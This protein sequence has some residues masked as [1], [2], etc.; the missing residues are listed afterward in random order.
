MAPRVCSM[1]PVA[2]RQ[3][4][5]LETSPQTWKL[6]ALPIACTGG[7]IRSPLPFD[8]TAISVVVVAHFH[9]NAPKNVNFLT[10]LAYCQNLRVA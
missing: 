6:P 5:Y 3:K 2:T 7:W 1:H 4:P 8:S 9:S 10:L